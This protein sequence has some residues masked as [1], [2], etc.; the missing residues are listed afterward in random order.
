MFDRLD[1]LYER[2]LPCMMWLYQAPVSAVDGPAPW[3]NIEVVS[4]WRAA[5]VAR[6]VA[7]AELACEEY[8]N[9]VDP[10]DVAG[11]LRA[12]APARALTSAP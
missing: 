7:A 3:F 6:F 2:P 12:L 4:P 10:T 5:G 1:R 11:R 8:F 9:P